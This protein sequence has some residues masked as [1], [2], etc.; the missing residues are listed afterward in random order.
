MHISRRNKTL[1]FLILTYSNCSQNTVFLISLSSQLKKT[2]SVLCESPIPL[3][4]KLKLAKV[5]EN[6][7]IHFEDNLV[8]NRIY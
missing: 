4:I 2:L 6:D 1:K 5:F 3:D 8:F 7:I